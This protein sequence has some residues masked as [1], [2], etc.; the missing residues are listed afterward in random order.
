MTAFVNKFTSS[1]LLLTC[2]SVCVALLFT[3]CDIEQSDVEPVVVTGSIIVTTHTP[4]EDEII[5]ASIFLD[6]IATAKSTPDTLF[7]IEIGQHEVEVSKLGYVESTQNVEVVAT[8][9]STAAIEMSIN[10]G[11][12]VGSMAYDFSLPSLEDSSIYTLFDYR[13]KVVLASFFTNNCAPCLVEFPHIQEVW[14]DPRFTDKIQFFGINGQ[15][16]WQI[17]VMFSDL[18]PELGLTFPL[19]H[20]AT[21][22]VRAVDYNVIA[23]PANFL[24]DQNGVIR[25]R[26]GS[27]TEELL[28]DAVQTLLAEA[29]Q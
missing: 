17:A 15:D 27:I 5:G 22:Q 26:W 4:E 20:D 28:E 12:E 29:D 16:I 18:H 9:T 19:L 11:S 6:G 13:G 14:E 1:M 23:H 24:I 25:Y 21:Q 7:D 3:S 2:L 8:L 10:W